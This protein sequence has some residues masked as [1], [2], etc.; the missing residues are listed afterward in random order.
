[1]QVRK[2][3]EKMN[4][5]T[6]LNSLDSIWHTIR[7]A[8]YDL[9]QGN[10]K[11]HGDTTDRLSG[12]QRIIRHWPKSETGNWLKG[13]SDMYFD[14]VRFELRYSAED[15]FTISLIF[16]KNGLAIEKV[17]FGNAVFPTGNGTPLHTGFLMGEN[18]PQ[19]K[20]LED[21]RMQIVWL[22]AYVS[23]KQIDRKAAEDMFCHVVRLKGKTP[24]HVSA[25][26]LGENAEVR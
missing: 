20:N 9:E 22:T 2:E 11:L 1:M 23:I 8:I 26:L 3:H 19:Y 12:A 14:N 5:K 24:G 17:A 21:I 15:N 7:E 4:N 6:S 25:C 10:V 18:G 13:I 16:L